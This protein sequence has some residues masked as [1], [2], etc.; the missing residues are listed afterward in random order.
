MPEKTNDAAD[1]FMRGFPA[2]PDVAIHRF[3]HEAMATMFGILITGCSKETAQQAALEA[4]RLVDKLELE[5][6]RFAQGS[7]IW[8]INKLSAGNWVHIGQATLDCLQLAQHAH[9]QTAGAFDIT[10]GSLIKYWRD[11]PIDHPASADEDFQ[12]ARLCTGMDLLEIN[13]ENYAAGVKTDGLRIDLG[14]IGKGYAVDRMTEVLKDWQINS[15]LAYGGNSSV[16]ALGT[17]ADLPGWPLSLSVPDKTKTTST[18]V[19]LKD[20]AFGASGLAVKGYHIIDP[21]TGTPVQHRHRCWSMAPT[22]AY[23]DALSTAFMIMP[24]NEIEK[25]C[26]THPK[27][28]ALIAWPGPDGFENRGFGNLKTI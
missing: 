9:Q 11:K 16:Y 28:S 14:G 19:F 26:S 23:A 10:V 4:F 5:L 2:M 20:Q 18:K 15:A 6:S 12:K 1:E 24:L 25:F 22:T 17:L 8:R 7:D 13:A 3:A 27:I 21:R